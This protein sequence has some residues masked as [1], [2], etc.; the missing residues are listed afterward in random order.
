MSTDGCNGE[1]PAVS[2]RH[3]LAAT[4]PDAL[5]SRPWQWRQRE[6]LVD[7]CE[8]DLAGG[9]GLLAVDDIVDKAGEVMNAL[10]S[11]SPT[12]P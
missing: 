10:A 12:R 9:S 11:V 6:R 4:C 3:R 8:P 1:V 5:H 2:A 7:E